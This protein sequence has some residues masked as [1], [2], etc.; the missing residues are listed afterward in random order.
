LTNAEIKGGQEVFVDKE[1]CFRM[2]RMNGIATT[3]V[4][5]EPIG[6]RFSGCLRR[7]GRFF[8]AMELRMQRNV[9]VG[10]RVTAMLRFG[11]V[12]FAAL[13]LL[14]AWMIWVFTDRVRVMVEVL[15]TMRIEFSQM[16]GNM[17][18]MQ[19]IIGGLEKDMA[20][21]SVVTEEM[22]VMQSTVAGMRGEV[23]EI[24]V[25]MG[26]LSGDVTMVNAHVSGMNQSFRLL[27]PAVTGIGASVNRGSAPMKTFYNLFPFSKILPRPI[28]R[29]KQSR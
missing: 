9:R 5:R 18:S 16:A 21:F 4:V 2:A 15:G 20:S 19:T 7:V 13:A 29:L 1:F 25:L 3:G 23:E 24:A 22:D 6:P 10:K 27:R 11:V 14:M 28:H 26:T 17:S 12:G 8:R